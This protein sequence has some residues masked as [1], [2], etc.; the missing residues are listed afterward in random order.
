MK[1]HHPALTTE[2]QFHMAPLIVWRDSP[3]I[4]L[5]SLS[6]ID[7]R[8]EVRTAHFLLKRRRPSTVQPTACYKGSAFLVR[9]SL[10]LV[11][12]IPLLIDRIIKMLNVN[13]FITLIVATLLVAGMQVTAYGGTCYSDTGCTQGPQAVGGPGKLLFTCF[14]FKPNQDSSLY[15]NLACSEGKTPVKK[16]VCGNIPGGGRAVPIECLN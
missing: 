10:P 8:N 12:P 15:S 2:H 1:K 11:S 13:D 16:G 7:P 3:Y 6:A 14:S 4:S 5:S 9:I